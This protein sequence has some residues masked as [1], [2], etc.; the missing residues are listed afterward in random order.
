M[1]LKV[2]PRRNGEI[3]DEERGGS[4]PAAKPNPDPHPT[5]SP[6]QIQGVCS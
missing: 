4:G 2:N 6:R 5:H 1:I 3:N